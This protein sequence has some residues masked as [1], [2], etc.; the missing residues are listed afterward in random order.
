MEWLKKKTKSWKDLRQLRRYE[1]D[2]DLYPDFVDKAQDIYI[3]A[4]EAL[5]M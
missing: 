1:E 2:F 3:K 5:A 4:H